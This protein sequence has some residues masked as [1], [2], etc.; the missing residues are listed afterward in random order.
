MRR[1]CID[2]YPLQSMAHASQAHKAAW[3]VLRGWAKH[4][5]RSRSSV[6]CVVKPCL[7]KYPT[8]LLSAY[9]RKCVKLS[10]D[11][12]NSCRQMADPQHLTSSP[13][14]QGQGKR[15]TATAMHC[16]VPT[17]LKLD[18]LLQPTE[19]QHHITL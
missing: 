13:S 17:G 11:L 1:A 16:S 15:P 2:P 12:A 18:L 14:N 10:F 6:T 8:A 5:T 3:T 19:N 4:R 9:V 7:L